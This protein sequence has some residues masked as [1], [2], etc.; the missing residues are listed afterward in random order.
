[1]KLYGNNSSRDNTKARGNLV[2]AARRAVRRSAYWRRLT[3]T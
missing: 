1:M 2:S 3:H